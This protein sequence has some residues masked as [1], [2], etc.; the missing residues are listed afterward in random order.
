[1]NRSVSL[2][3][4]AAITS[5]V[6]GSGR[7]SHR[8]PLRNGS[9]VT[10]DQPFVRFRG[11]SQYCAYTSLRAA[12]SRMYNASFAASGDEFVTR[13]G[14][15]GASV[16]CS[17]GGSTPS[18]TLSRFRSRW[19]PTRSVASWRSRSGDGLGGRRSGGSTSVRLGGHARPVRTG[20][21]G[22]ATPSL[23]G[24]SVYRQTRRWR[25]LLLAAPATLSTWPS[26]RVIWSS[27]R[28]CTP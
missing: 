18:V 24:E 7:R 16:G 12:K 21:D 9:R 17:A 23:S 4:C 2:R 20:L 3:R 1:M 15:V 14:S 28:R 5:V 8:V 22:A 25:G 27:P 11:F 13:P 6:S 10:G 26:M 19:F